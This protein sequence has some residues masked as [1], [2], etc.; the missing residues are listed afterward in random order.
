[1]IWALKLLSQTAQIQKENETNYQ[2]GEKEDSI[3]HVSQETSNSQ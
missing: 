1:M 2:R 3:K